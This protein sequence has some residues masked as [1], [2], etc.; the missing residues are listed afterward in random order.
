ML[1]C[2][3]ATERRRLSRRVSQGRV[4][5]TPELRL[6][7]GLRNLVDNFPGVD[8]TLTP[9]QSI[10]LRN[11]KPADRNDVE[12]LLKFH[13]VKMINDIDSIT[14]KSIAC[15]AYP[16]CGLAITE[17]ERVQ[18]HINERLVAQ[19]RKMGL[20]DLSFVTRTTG[21]PNGCAR[22]YMAE[23]AFVG[24]GPST[25]QLWLGGSP[26]QSE[27]TG[28]A[29]DIFKMQFQGA[30]VTARYCPLLSY[31]FKMQFQG[32]HLALAPSPGPTPHT[33]M[34]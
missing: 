1:C 17:A 5:D 12:T 9:S 8:M 20:S 28:F 13:G 21:C 7:S 27:R 34:T 32:A 25:Y 18:P 3:S 23:I 2:R 16:L 10:V 24:S 31:I 33:L 11:I 4:R 26:D 22:P 30:S 15:P 19:L 14:R 29:T 6:K